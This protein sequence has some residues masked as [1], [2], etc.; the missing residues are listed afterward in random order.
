MKN[1]IWDFDGMLFDT[2]PHTHAAFCDTCRRF[3]IPAEPDEVMRQLKITIWDAMNFYGFDDEMKARFYETEN[4]LGFLPLGKPYPHI[5]EILAYITE[6]G[7]KNF[8]YTHRDKV[9]LR[10]FEKY[11]LSGFFAG[12]VTRENG[13]PH[14]PAPDAIEYIIREYS[15]E[16]NECMMLGDRAIDVG[17][18]LNAG[19]SACLFDEFGDLPADIECTY[20]CG[21]TEEIA[22]LIKKLLK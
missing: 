19:I 13:F 20:R 1:F 2:Y 11:E 3:H 21:S 15:L 12:A 5:P 16:K 10:Y 4:D 6:H 8:L 18:G 17:S 22:A 14:K 9:A 7:G